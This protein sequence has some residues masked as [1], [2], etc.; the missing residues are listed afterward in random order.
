MAL[1][2]VALPSVKGRVCRRGVEGLGKT[3]IDLRLRLCAAFLS[4]KFYRAFHTCHDFLTRAD[5]MF[6]GRD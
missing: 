2:E 6:S 1:G 3:F 5:Q 4:S